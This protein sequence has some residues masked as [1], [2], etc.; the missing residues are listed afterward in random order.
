[1]A[2]YV[3]AT[4]QFRLEELPVE[5][6][7]KDIEGYEGLYQVSNL[8]NVRSL[9]YNRQGRVKNL[10]SRLGGRGYYV[11]GLCSNG[12]PKTTPIHRIVAM[13]FVQNPEGFPCVNHKDENPRNNRADNPKKTR[14][15][16]FK[17]C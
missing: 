9:N 16:R 15:D 2:G 17:T 4:L 12:K 7:W 1:M 11:V 13:A 8:G 3:P 6:I 14:K 10:S 5:E